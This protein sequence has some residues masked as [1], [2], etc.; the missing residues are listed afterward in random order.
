MTQIIFQT[1]QS[2]AN[3]NIC[4]T[5]VASTVTFNFSLISDYQAYSANIVMKKGS[6]TTLP[7]TVTVYDQPNGGGSSLGSASV[8]ASAVTQSF[9][10]IEFVFSSLNLTSGVAYSLVISSAESCSGS[11]PYSFKSGNFQIVDRVT[12]GVINT[13]Y[14]IVMNAYGVTTMGGSPKINAKVSSSSA[15]L[16]TLS[17][18]AIKSR[19][20]DLSMGAVATLN[21]ALLAARSAVLSLKSESGALAS[22]SLDVSVS[23]GIGTESSLLGIIGLDLPVSCVASCS[24]ELQSSAEV[25]RGCE[26]ES[27]SAC[28]VS[29]EA[30]LVLGAEAS[31]QAIS[32]LEGEITGAKSLFSVFSECVASSSMVAEMA[33][34]RPSAADIQCETSFSASA[35]VA[36]SANLFVGA[37]SLLSA[38]LSSGKKRKRREGSGHYVLNSGVFTL[39][40]WKRFTKASDKHITKKSSG[41]LGFR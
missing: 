37:S 33:V 11:S 25:V 40:Q 17:A 24:S 1:D 30:S 31:V 34:E 4:S 20:M 29:A 18:S 38:D 15:F 2:G 41:T 12:G 3:Q 19:A 22:A 36:L 5:A 10:P 27:A 26:L 32:K 35:A 21:S 16:A 7:V 13:G 14:G 8:L 28:S 23:S 39:R 6:G 9:S